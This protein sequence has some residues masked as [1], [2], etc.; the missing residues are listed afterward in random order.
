MKRSFSRQS[1]SGPDFLFNQLQTARGLSIRAEIDGDAAAKLGW[2]ERAAGYTRPAAAAGR[3][4]RYE[5]DVLVA[6][7]EKQLAAVRAGKP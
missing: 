3:L 5:R 2:L 7:I 1:R 6:G 4:T